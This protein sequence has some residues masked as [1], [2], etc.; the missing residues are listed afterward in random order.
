MI[1]EKNQIGNAL[2]LGQSVSSEWQ[3][4]TQKFL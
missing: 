3:S 2:L 4:P 1:R